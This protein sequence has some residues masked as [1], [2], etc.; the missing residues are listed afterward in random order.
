[1]CDVLVSCILDVDD[2]KGRQVSDAASWATLW[3]RYQIQ[4]LPEV[5]RCLPAVTVVLLIAQYVSS[6]GRTAHWTLDDQARELRV[7]IRI[8]GEVPIATWTGGPVRSLISNLSHMKDLFSTEIAR[9]PNRADIAH[10][11]IQS[12]T[13][14]TL[15]VSEAAYRPRHS[16]PCVFQFLTMPQEFA[17]QQQILELFRVVRRGP[18]GRI[19]IWTK[20]GTEFFARLDEG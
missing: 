12:T 6:A 2:G 17:T 8:L 10:I 15:I 5:N 1:M 20:H 4:R 11:G 19:Q 14:W 16:G 18:D 13:C 9:L 7:Q 3:R